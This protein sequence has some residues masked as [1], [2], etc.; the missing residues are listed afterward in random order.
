M[1]ITR[2]LIEW[3]DEVTGRARA[4][5]LQEELLRADAEISRLRAL[6]AEATRPATQ[7]ARMREREIAVR[8]LTRLRVARQ[9]RPDTGADELA[10]ARAQRDAVE[11]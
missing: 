5:R 4:R 9:G 1:M 8:R 3:F 10:G 7:F 11:S 2:R 6:L